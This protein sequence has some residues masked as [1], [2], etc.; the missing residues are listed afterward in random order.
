MVLILLFSAC[1]DKTGWLSVDEACTASPDDSATPAQQAFDRAA[2]YR[3]RL[4]LD[5]AALDDAV[6]AASQAH[7]DYMAEADTLAHEE[8]DT[9]N[10]HYTGEWAWDR[11]EAAGYRSDGVVA[12]V[13]AEGYSPSEAVD[14]WVNSVYHRIPFTMPEWTAVGFGQSERFCAMTFL[15]PFPEG[16]P[17]AIIYPADGQSE[18]PTTFLSDQEYPDPAPDTNA[19]GS[20]ITVTVG[21]PDAEIIGQN[22]YDLQLVD[23]TLTGPDGDVDVIVLV[24]DDD[25]YLF[26]TLALVPEAP[27]D[28]GASYTAAISVTWSSGE[29][30]L[31]STFLTAR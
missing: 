10:S 11:V 30:T 3:A 1:T 2:C 6:L 25:P 31:S 23:A 13:V 7:A 22:R 14:S 12:E 21:G 26:N 4:G 28:A 27:L 29:A 9:S 19:V 16:S 18:V 20:P 15:T 5:P 24:P 17:A 8:S